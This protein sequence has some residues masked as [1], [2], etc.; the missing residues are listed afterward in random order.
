[1]P[2]F[3][4]LSNGSQPTQKEF[5][6]D[7]V[8]HQNLITNVIND[9]QAYKQRLISYVKDEV[10]IKKK[11]K[12]VASATKRDVGSESSRGNMQ[13]FDVEGMVLE[14]KLFEEEF[15]HFQNMKA[16]L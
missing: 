3:N 16:R 7:L 13:D 4:Y 2:K 15:T 8:E 14:A 5:V 10:D 6:K 11:S 12:R 1:M 9:L